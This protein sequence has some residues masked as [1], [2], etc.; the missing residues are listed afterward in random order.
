M[1]I[2][3]EIFFESYKIYPTIQKPREI[4]KRSYSRAAVDDSRPFHRPPY[5][6]IPGSTWLSLV[7]SRPLDYETD[8]PAFHADVLV[9]NRDYGSTILPASTP[10]RA[11]VRIAVSVQNV[12][13]E[14]PVFRAETLVST[15][16]RIA[17]LRCRP[18]SEGRVVTKMSLR[19]LCRK[20]LL[21]HCLL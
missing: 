3:I 20:C 13:D 11:V 5:S 17:D 8:G 19:C 2:A 10:L 18:Q 16:S 15:V 7:S 12:E 9:E 21:G 6:L 1:N 4:P 14:P